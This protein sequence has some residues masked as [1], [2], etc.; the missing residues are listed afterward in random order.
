[1]PYSKLIGKGH[2]VGG[3]SKDFIRVQLAKAHFFQFVCQLLGDELS[4]DEALTYFLPD[5]ATLERNERDNEPMCSNRLQV[6][7]YA[8]RLFNGVAAGQ[9]AS[10]SAAIDNYNLPLTL[11]KTK[12]AYK[13]AHK[14][15]RL[16]DQRLPENV[17]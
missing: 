6:Y 8:L 11:K 15:T 1:M 10:V 14:A 12:N 3:L 9:W 2:S 7:G 17:E 4:Y 16:D 5:S 13:A